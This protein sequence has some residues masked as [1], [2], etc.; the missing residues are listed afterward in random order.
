MSL[1]ELYPK[2]VKDNIIF[3]IDIAKQCAESDKHIAHLKVFLTKDIIHFFNLCL[4]TY[5]PRK[6][7]KHRPFILYDYQE[8]FVQELNE[9][10]AKGQDYLIDK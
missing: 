8:E 6:T 2:K 1:D 10:I 7:P 3:R 4:W 5:D 9:A